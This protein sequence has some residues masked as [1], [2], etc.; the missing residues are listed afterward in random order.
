MELYLLFKIMNSREEHV[1]NYLDLTTMLLNLMEGEIPA[2]FG[3]M[4]GM[5]SV[6]GMC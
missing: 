6:L 3:K 5:C 2:S 4:S 1:R